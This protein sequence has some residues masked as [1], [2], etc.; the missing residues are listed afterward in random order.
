MT[1]IIYVFLLSIQ[2]YELHK[3]ISGRR[4]FILRVGITVIL[5]LKTKSTAVSYSLQLQKPLY[6]KGFPEPDVKSIQCKK[7]GWECSGSSEY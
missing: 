4:D 2:T 7:Y 1:L 3:D 6:A 5:P